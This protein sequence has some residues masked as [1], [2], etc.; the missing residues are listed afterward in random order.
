MFFFGV[1]F[2]FLIVGTN[3]WS[4]H[5]LRHLKLGLH[6]EF[7]LEKSKEISQGKR[8]HAEK[9][10]NLRCWGSRYMSAKKR[11]HKLRK[12]AISETSKK[13]PQHSLSVLL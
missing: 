10:T 5:F 7:S 4:P 11:A 13:D 8:R 3:L 9:N 2:W 12:I 1:V 6:I